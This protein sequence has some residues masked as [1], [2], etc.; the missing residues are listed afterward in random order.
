VKGVNDSY[1][2]YGQINSQGQMHGIGNM[3]FKNGFCYQGMFN[4]GSRDGLGFTF[5]L[6]G[7]KYKGEHRKGIR[8]G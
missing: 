8:E 2:Y 6:A 4:K 7:N 3:L 1:V 5:D